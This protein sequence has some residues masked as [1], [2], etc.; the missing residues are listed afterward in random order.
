M[1]TSA[2]EDPFEGADPA[3]LAANYHPS[4]IWTEIISF[5]KGSVEA[6]QSE[7]GFL[8]RKQYFDLGKKRAPNFLGI[9]VAAHFRFL[10]H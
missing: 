5:I 7:N 6:L 8:E 9:C 10:L 2:T 1:G 3:Q 4:L